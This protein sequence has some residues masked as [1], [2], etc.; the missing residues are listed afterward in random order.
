MKT[1]DFNKIVEDFL[2]KTKSTLIRKQEEYNL[3]ADRFGFFKRA[4]AMAGNSPE[5][6]LYGFL[7]KHLVSLSDMVGSGKKFSKALYE[8]K[9]GDIVN[10][11]ILLRGLLEDDHMFEEEK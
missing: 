7:L 4:A 11:L 10:Y 2:E 9:L 3:E 8:E 6:A 1:T 5:Q